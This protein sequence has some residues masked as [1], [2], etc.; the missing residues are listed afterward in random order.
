MR[1][2][3][4]QLTAD[5]SLGHFTASEVGPAGRKPAAGQADRQPGWFRCGA[6][7][8]ELSEGGNNDFV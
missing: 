4:F 5:S 7:D 3:E 1:T 8:R 2:L 6:G